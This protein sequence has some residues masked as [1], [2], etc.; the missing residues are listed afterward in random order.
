VAIYSGQNAEI[1]LVQIA[2]DADDEGIGKPA[3]RHNCKI[4]GCLVS[5]QNQHPH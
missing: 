2:R 1:V 3:E 4:T 5:M